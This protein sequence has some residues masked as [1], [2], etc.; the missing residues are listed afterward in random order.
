MTHK[1]NL[2][3]SIYC[4]FLIFFELFGKFPLGG[5][6]GPEKDHD[7]GTAIVLRL[8]IVYHSRGFSIRGGGIQS[9]HQMVQHRWAFQVIT[10]W[11]GI[12]GQMW[13]SG[14]NWVSWSVIWSRSGFTLVS[15]PY[16]SFS[17]PFKI[18]HRVAHHCYCYP[19]LL[20]FLE[21]SFLMFS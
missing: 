13:W 20:S 7:S 1:F 12:V 11:F 3:Q 18:V 6:G 16:F 15:V 14:L 5:F 21:P 19:S 10:R 8:A 2:S 4:G 17:S 9:H